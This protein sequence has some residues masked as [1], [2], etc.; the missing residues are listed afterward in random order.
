MKI[1]VVGTPAQTR[2][3]VLA[4]L[5]R[6]F[7]ETKEYMEKQKEEA[8]KEKMV[9]TPGSFRSPERVKYDSVVD[10]LQGRYKAYVYCQGPSDVVRAYDLSKKY[11][12][13]S[14]YLLGPECYKAADFIAEKKLD[15]ILDPELIYY[16]RNPLTEEVKKID[17]ARVF[18]EKGIA[19]ALISYPGRVHT[20]SLSYQAM[21]ALASGLSSDDV[22]KAVTIV[23]ARMLGADDLIGSIEKGKLAS[24]VVLNDDPFKLSTKVEFVYADG[25]LVYERAKDEELN[26][27]LERNVIK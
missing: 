4:Q 6:Y 27:L 18:H 20:R 12:Y 11:G 14:V 2:M 5:R 25:K 22:L 8:Q 24:F 23:P 21:R 16:E 13:S 19:F 10:L 17:V 1:S 15:I 7:D 3:G 9:S 26:K